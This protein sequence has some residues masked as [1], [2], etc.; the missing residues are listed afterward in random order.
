MEGV[1]IAPA[2]PPTNNPIML[3]TVL[4][5]PRLKPIQPNTRKAA[6]IKTSIKFI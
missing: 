1:A 5:M 6:G 2:A 3:N 4:K